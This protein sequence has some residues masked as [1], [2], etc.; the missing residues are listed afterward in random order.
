MLPP[1]DYEILKFGGVP[2]KS[3]KYGIRIMLKNFSS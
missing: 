2:I 3:E 1:D